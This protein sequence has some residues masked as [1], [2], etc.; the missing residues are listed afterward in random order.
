MMKI[1]VIGGGRWAR[2]IAL[3]LGTMPGRSDRIT[4]HSPGNSEGVR[5][6]I[7]Q[8]RL[9]DRIK[10]AAAWPAFET[11]R[12]RPDA[13]VVA[14]RARDHFAAAAAALQ[15]GIPSLVEKPISL[16]RSQIENLCEI[17]RANGTVFQ[18]SQVFLF[19]RYFETYCT[20]VAGLGR[21]HSLR[22]VW[23]DGASDVRRGEAKSY[24]PAVTVFDD[25]LPHIVPMIAQLN[26]R[27]FS[28]GSLDVQQ[29]GARLA[30]EAQSEGRP[31]C[32]IMARNGQARR[33]QIEVVAEAGSATLDFSD[34]P[35]FIDVSGVRENGDPLWNS[36][37]R[38]LTAMLSAFVAAANGAALDGRLSPSRAVAA[39]NL[40][41]NIRGRYF[42]YQAEWL[43]KRLGEPLDPSLRYALIE[44]S[45]DA[46]RAA[47]TITAVWPAMDTGAHLKSFLAKNPLRSNADYDE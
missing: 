24:D 41:E 47:D 19:A 30:V 18:A 8:R 20:S 31:I 38:P 46:D 14:N 39:A 4:V 29:G 44:L 35:G 23:T 12:E 26:F 15:A 9:G 37:P 28:L 45:S 22:F 33:R 7:E 5:A 3:V 34:E 21:V 42:A 1:S 2:T 25:V 17:A 10:A 43:E 27:D 32:L 6:W 11:G 16:A 36:A 40:A 13:V